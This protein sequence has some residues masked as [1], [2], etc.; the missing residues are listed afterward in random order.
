MLWNVEPNIEVGI[1]DIHLYSLF[2]AL[3]LLFGGLAVMKMMNGLTISQSYFIYAFLGIFIGARLFHCF[4]YEPSYFLQHPFEILLPCSFQ[5]GKLQFIGYQGLASHGGTVG[6]M[7]ALWIFAKK[8]RANYLQICDIFA[9]A[10]PLAGGFIRLG[11]LVNS[12]IIGK[13]T[14]VSWAFIFPKID[15]VPRHPAQLYEAI[16]YFLLAIFMLIMFKK[17][18]F[19]FRYGFYMGIGFFGVALFRFF[20][21]FLKEPQ[22]NFDNLTALNMGQILSIPFIIAGFFLLIFT[23]KRKKIFINRKL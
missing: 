8:N 1:F 16:W 2:F 21:E 17:I 4:F 3:G 5:D 6:L 10:T 20:I 19:K 11:N 18:G 14:S 23:T 7:V 9:V 13:P 15:L 12:E 22:T